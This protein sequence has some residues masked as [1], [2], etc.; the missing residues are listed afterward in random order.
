MSNDR[1]RTDLRTLADE[2][3]MTDL[4][5]RT[6]RTSRRIAVRRAVTASAAVVAVVVVVTAGAFAAGPRHRAHRPA[7]GN[8]APSPSVSPVPSPHPTS[9][10][11]PAGR[12]GGTT[13]Y[14]ALQAPDAGAGPA[15]LHAVTGGA[16]RIVLSLPIG[17]AQ[18]SY[19]T[20]SVS[21]GGTRVAWVTDDGDLDVSRPDGSHPVVVSHD[22]ACLAGSI[23]W[24]GDDRFTVPSRKNSDRVVEVDAAAGTV[25]DPDVPVAR[26][27]PASPNGTWVAVHTPAGRHYVARMDGSGRRD[28]DVPA[29]KVPGDSD[30]WGARGVSDDGRYV[31]VGANSTG[32]SRDQSAFA[33]VD[34]TTGAPAH[35]PVTGPIRFVE[36]RPDG[37]VLVVTDTRYTL[38]D[39]SLHVVAHQPVS[40]GKLTGVWLAC[41]L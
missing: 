27:G 1:L 12:V 19:E 4:R 16:D 34:L 20:V 25:T 11:L 26:Q 9:S 33:I 35:L 5:D 38:L 28:F 6:L 10:A 17:P 30:G 13:Y 37:D 24:R 18:C 40:L 22:G 15:E 36:F 3:S 41:V 29:N 21:P 2:V 7:P 23:A 14:V 39:H 31:A 8:T 32:M